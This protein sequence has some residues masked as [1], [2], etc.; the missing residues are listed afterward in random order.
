[1][2]LT[3]RHLTATP[4]TRAGPGSAPAPGQSQT[5]GTQEQTEAHSGDPVVHC[6]AW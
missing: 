3:G 6:E 2:V 1:M 4:I 5:Q